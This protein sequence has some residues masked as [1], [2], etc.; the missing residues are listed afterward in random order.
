MTYTICE[1]HFLVVTLLLNLVRVLMLLC[2]ITHISIFQFC[3]HF[4]R[5]LYDKNRKN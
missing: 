5:T 1:T 2:G 4:E 3:K